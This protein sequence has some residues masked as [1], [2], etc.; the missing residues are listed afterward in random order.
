MKVR[1][2]TEK[3]IPLVLSFIRDLAKYEDLLD[4]VKI[5]EETIYNWIFVQ[6]KVEAIFA[7]EDG[8]E[9][10]FALYY[11]TFSTFAGKAGIYLEDLF[12]QPEYR[13]KGYGRSLLAA[14]AEIAIHKGCFRI[15]WMCLTWN[16]P[17]Q[18]FYR[19]LGAKPVDDWI[20]FRLTG[21][22]LQQL[23]KS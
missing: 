12:V 17:S 19:S 23:A 20:T 14:L 5:D 22:A 11:Y 7:I 15:D 18:N 13:G 10:G 6:K 2:A 8:V 16:T 4:T 21:D 3:D 1:L 9:V